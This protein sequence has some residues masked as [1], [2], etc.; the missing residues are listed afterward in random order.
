MSLDRPIQVAV[1][2]EVPGNGRSAE[3]A[4]VL[5]RRVKLADAVL[6]C[7]PVVPLRDRLAWS[8]ADVARLLGLSRRHLERLRKDGSMPPPDIQLG[9]RRVLLWRPATINRWLDSQGGS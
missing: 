1:E 8:L 5:P 4:S 9:R 2:A 3:A 6:N 7:N